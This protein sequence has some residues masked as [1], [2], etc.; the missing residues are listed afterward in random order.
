M[1]YIMES[2]KLCIDCKY[3]VAVRNCKHPSL[4]ISLVDGTPNTDFCAVM[5]SSNRNCGVEAALFE[6]VE[7]VIY[8]LAELFPEAPFPNLRKD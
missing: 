3:Y 5:R 7:A 4:G 6:P 2:P 1:G 8:D